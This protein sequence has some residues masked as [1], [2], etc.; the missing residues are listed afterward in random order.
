MMSF[1]EFLK[2]QEAT[3]KA[4]AQASE[5]L[6]KQWETA[7]LDLMT[8][9]KSW[10]SE[11]DPDRLLQIKDHVVTIYDNQID[12]PS[13]PGLDIFMGS[14]AISIRPISAKTVIGPRRKPVEGEWTG[15]VDLI[16][17]PYSFELWLLVD[18]QGESRWYI[19]DDRKYTLHPLTRESLENA[20][21]ELFS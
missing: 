2:S 16:G 18:A 17:N 21:V 10:L 14:R 11:S 1:K 5:R 19:R 3:I 13:L 4:E 20:L 12:Q 6:K 15:R 9:I 8:T 7:L